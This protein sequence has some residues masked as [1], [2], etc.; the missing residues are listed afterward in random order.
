[1]QA[2]VFQRRRLVEDPRHVP[3]VERADVEVAVLL[4]RG[5]QHPVEREAGKGDEAEGGGVQRD[6]LHIAPPAAPPTS[7]RRASR[8]IRVAAT[9][10]NGSRKTAMAAP[11]PRSAPWM[12]RWKASVGRTCV[13]LAGPPPVRMYTTPKSVAV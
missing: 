2:H 3:R 5:D 12:P 4:E 7:V 9:I 10:R 6:A 13:V 11:W 8:S 1:E